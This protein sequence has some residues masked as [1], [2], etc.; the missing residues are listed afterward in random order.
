MAR[1]DGFCRQID[2]LDYVWIPFVVASGL[3]ATLM[4]MQ[5]IFFPAL[6]DTTTRLQHLQIARILRAPDISNQ[7]YY[8]VVHLKNLFASTG[9][10]RGIRD[11]AISLNWSSISH[12][13]CKRRAS[14]LCF[15]AR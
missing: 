8:Q 4:W 15:D 2:A 5:P 12:S 10:R 11:N 9:P 1:S 7:T 13:V 6:G 14:I 3:L